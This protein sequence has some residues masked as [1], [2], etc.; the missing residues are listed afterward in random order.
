M[1]WKAWVPR[2]QGG[3]Q[4]LR[5]EGGRCDVGAHIPKHGATFPR[6]ARGW[7]SYPSDRAGGLGWGAKVTGAGDQGCRVRILFRDIH[8]VL[9]AITATNDDYCGTPFPQHLLVITAL[10]LSITSKAPRPP[11]PHCL[12][13]ISVEICSLGRGAGRGQRIRKRRGRLPVIWIG[14]P[15]CADLR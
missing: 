1:F 14:F 7:S 8:I 11:L 4:L 6:L 2:R 9:A 5:E 13:A 10:V 12:P 3:R 15:V